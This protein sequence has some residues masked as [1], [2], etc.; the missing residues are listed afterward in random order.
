MNIS[1]SVRKPLHSLQKPTCGRWYL[2]L[3]VDKIS[4]LPKTMGLFWHSVNFIYNLGAIVGTDLV[5]YAE[6]AERGESLCPGVRDQLEHLQSSWIKT[7]IHL[8]RI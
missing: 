8:Y 1:K 5:S 4:S 3:K 6:E 2:L 7:Q